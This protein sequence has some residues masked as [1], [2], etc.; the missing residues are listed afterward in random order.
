MA[1]CWRLA[2]GRRPLSATGATMA[3]EAASRAAAAVLNTTEAFRRTD[4]L[5]TLVQKPNVSKPTTK[6]QEIEAW[7]DWKHGTQELPPRT[8][9]TC[10]RW[11]PSR[12]TLPGLLRFLRWQMTQSGGQGNCVPFGFPSCKGA[13]P[14][15]PAGFWTKTAMKRGATSLWRCSLAADSA[16]WR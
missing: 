3:A 1:G 14:T 11:T 13:Q 10:R 15:L 4:L 12:A 2:L 16:N 5:R 9:S 6:D 7:S 8:R